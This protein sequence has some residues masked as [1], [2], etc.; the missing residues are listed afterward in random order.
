L[1]LAVVGCFEHRD[2][3][4]RKFAFYAAAGR[5]GVN[6]LDADRLAAQIRRIKRG[7]SAPFVVVT[8]HWGLDYSRRRK[9]EEKTARAAIDAGA[10]LVIG[11]GAHHCQTVERYKKRWILYNIGNFM[12]NSPGRYA[13]K[14]SHATS[15]VVR[16]GLRPAGSG[17]ATVASLRCYPI[18]TDNLRSA[19]RSR[20]VSAR[21][22]QRVR[23]LLARTSPDAAGFRRGVR[24]GRDRLGRYLELRTD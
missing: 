24:A 8:P 7:P 20:P 23:E 15:L 1:R 2:R 13:E 19:Y 16:L 5:P 10:D 22:F 17:S 18:F 6:R 9:L 14:D 3:Y 12:F 21:E 4:D 11:H